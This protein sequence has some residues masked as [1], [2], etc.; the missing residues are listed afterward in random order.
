MKVNKFRGKKGKILQNLKEKKRKRK[1][2]I[3]RG[4]DKTSGNTKHQNKK[5]LQNKGKE[6]NISYYKS[7]N[8]LYAGFP[9]RVLRFRSPSGERFFYHQAI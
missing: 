7:T 9:S 2:K 4:S 6:K 8:G 1:Q 3:L 5:L